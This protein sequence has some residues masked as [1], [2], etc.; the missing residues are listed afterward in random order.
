MTLLVTNVSDMKET[1]DK[2][3]PIQINVHKS[4]QKHGHGGVCNDIH[5][6]HQLATVTFYC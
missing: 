4:A 1:H 5:C 3:F 2:D 6:S